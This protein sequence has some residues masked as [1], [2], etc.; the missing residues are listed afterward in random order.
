MLMSHSYRRFVE[1][2]E[3]AYADTKSTLILGSGNP[4]ANVMVVGFRPQMGEAKVFSGSITSRVRQVFADLNVPT[5]YVWWTYV[6]KQ[7]IEKESL[8]WE[9]VEP[10]YE[11]F[12]HEIEAIKPRA[13]VLLGV[14]TAWAVLGSEEGNVDALRQHR[15]LAKHIP[16]TNFFVTYSPYDI[17]KFSPY[18]ALEQEWQKDLV[19]V[20][21]AQ[22]SYYSKQLVFK[23][24]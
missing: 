1:R 7:C 8:M 9:D 6:V 13:V 2:L 24:S 4:L 12:K 11:H 3:H 23:A 18:Q 19:A 10:W 14:D 17:E 20:F 15:C 21:N 16:I 22:Q 5:H